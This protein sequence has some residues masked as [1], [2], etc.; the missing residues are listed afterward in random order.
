MKS[1]PDLH[2]GLSKTASWDNRFISL[3]EF[4]AEWSEERGRKVGAVI[5]GQKNTILSIGYNGLPRGVSAIPDNRHSRENDEKY[6]WFEHAERNAIYNA[7]RTGTSLENS[8][9][10]S[11]LF[12]CADCARAIVQ[13]G[14]AELITRRPP[15]SEKHYGK[16]M[17]ISSEIFNEASINIRFI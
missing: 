1:D 3:C 2:Q 12:P 16:S 15:V 4:V 10:Y 7:A 8:R 11:S 14:I 17:D 13:S 6:F 5:V 9:I